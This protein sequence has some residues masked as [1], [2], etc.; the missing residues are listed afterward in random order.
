MSA[1]IP[2]LPKSKQLRACLLCSVIQ[3][4]LDFRKNGCP[5]CEELMQVRWAF[6]MPTP[7]VDQSK[8]K[9]STDRTN[10]CT[11]TYFDGV[12]AVI[13]P[14][15][16]WVARWQRTGA[17][18]DPFRPPTVAH[19]AHQQS[20]L[21]GCTPSASKAAY[22]KT[23]KLSSVV[24]A[25]NIVLVIRPIRTKCPARAHSSSGCSS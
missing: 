8:M 15:A 4:P 3:H 10:A 22:R 13:D 5:N 6:S 11:S 1:A 16:S 20:M 9:G 24:E 2:P 19:P 7:N 12:I 18:L 14:E 21:E 17:F 23:S 25:S